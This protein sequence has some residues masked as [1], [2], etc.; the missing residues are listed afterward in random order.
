MTESTS[1]FAVDQTAWAMF[2]RSKRPLPK[3]RCRRTASALK[4]AAKAA[5]AS[6]TN[7][8]GVIERRAARP[9]P[10]TARRAPPRS[11]VPGRHRAPPSPIRRAS[12][13]SL[14]SRRT[15]AASA[16]GS[17]AG[18]SSALSPSTSSSR[19]AGVSAVT[20]GVPQASAWNALFGIT[21]PVFAEV[22]K[23]PRAHP[24]RWSSSGRCSYSTHSTHS[25]LGGRSASSPS[26]WPLP[27]MRNGISGASRAAARIVSTPWSGI[28]LPTKSAWNSC[29]GCQPGRKRRSSAPT[30]QTA[31]RSAGSSASSARCRAFWAVSATTRSARRSASRSTWRRTPAAGE[32]VEKRPRSST[33]VSCS[34]TSGLKTTGRPRAIRR[35]AGT[36]KWPG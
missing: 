4:P 26:S 19:A 11:P 23:T 14:A 34:E 12:A 17:P 30:K 32:P 3:A 13:A 15:A 20:S 36:S 8:D 6:Q 2:P 10:A 35:A 21:R 7:R 27:T 22:P 31:S 18:T 28:S 1:P 25:T 16:S 29:G 24:A 9:G 33:R 5:V